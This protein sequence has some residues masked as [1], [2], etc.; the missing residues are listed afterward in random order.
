[1]FLRLAACVP[2]ALGSQEEAGH[3][4]A[5][6]GERVGKEGERALESRGGM[7]ALVIN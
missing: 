4:A 6:Q 5:L 1:M 7:K 2:Y 3:L